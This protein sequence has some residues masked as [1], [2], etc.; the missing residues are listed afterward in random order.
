MM[1]MHHG[2]P[3]ASRDQPAVQW[4]GGRPGDEQRDREA[5]RHLLCGVGSV[6]AIHTQPVCNEARYNEWHREWAER[7]SEKKPITCSK[8]RCARAAKHLH[9]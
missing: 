9:P 3:P 1:V 5:L 4:K 8:Y 2:V 6:F 7:L